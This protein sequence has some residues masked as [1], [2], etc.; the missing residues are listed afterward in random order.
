MSA[1]EEAFLKSWGVVKMPN[2]SYVAAENTWSDMGQL[3]EIL[4][5]MLNDEEYLMDMSDHELR[6]L[7]G[8]P[9]ACEQLSELASDVVAQYSANL[10]RGVPSQ[11]MLEN[12][13]MG[14]LDY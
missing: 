10:A 7:K 3:I 9:G 12:E 5:E 8:I 14:E 4:E 6:A 1:F 13:E 11:T 2:M